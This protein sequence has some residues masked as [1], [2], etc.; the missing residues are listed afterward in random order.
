[1]EGKIMDKLSELEQRIEEYKQQSLKAEKIALQKLTKYPPYNR[2]LSAVDVLRRELLR[3][4]T[5]TLLLNELQQWI[6]E[7]KGMRLYQLC[8]IPDAVSRETQVYSV[9]QYMTEREAA[10]VNTTFE[11]NRERLRW[12]PVDSLEEERE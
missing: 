8:A 3:H 7:L 12:K 5:R 6:A 4:H 10:E 11:A 1:V 9:R 2:P